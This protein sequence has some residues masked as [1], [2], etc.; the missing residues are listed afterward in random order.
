MYWKK[1]RGKTRYLDFIQSIQ[2]RLVG[3]QL[4]NYDKKFWI[5]HD[6]DYDLDQAIDL[7]WF[8]MDNGMMSTF[9][10]LHTAGYF[11]Y[12]YEFDRKITKLLA[13]GHAIGF[14]NDLLG[15]WSEKGGD[16]YKIL[17]PPLNFLRQITP[18]TSTS[19]HGKREYYDRNFI[20]YEVWQEYDSSQN[21][22]YPVKWDQ[23]SLK[24]VGLNEAYFLPYTHYFS[25]SGGNW[26]GYQVDGQK[27]FERSALRSQLNIGSDIVEKFNEC[28]K[29]FLQL[30]IHPEHWECVK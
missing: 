30:L 13:M 8:E 15:V 11:D 19:S 12:S 26:I 7:A 29:G 20:N 22:G 25:D 14:H 18:V 6:V 21:E 5:R 23:I 24:Y 10:L 16:V 1:K 3:S 17:Q 2:G 9:F 28:E 27:P 4:S